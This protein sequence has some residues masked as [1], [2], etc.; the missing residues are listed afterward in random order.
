[1]THYEMKQLSRTRW[2]AQLGC[3]HEHL[4]VEVV[5]EG[6]E[7]WI[8]GVRHCLPLEDLRS[9][10]SLVAGKPDDISVYCAK[11]L[12]ELDAYSEPPSRSI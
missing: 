3:R 8:C 10:L 5:P 4:E 1:M 7:F 12:G 6:L 2:S 9:A 11:I